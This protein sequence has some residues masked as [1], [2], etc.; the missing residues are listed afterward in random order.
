MNR[1]EITPTFSPVYST[2]IC[3]TYTDIK[4]VW[5]FATLAQK[6]DRIW[7]E[8]SVRFS[9]GTFRRESWEKRSSGLTLHVSC[10]PDHRLWPPMTREAWEG[11]PLWMQIFSLGIVFAVFST[12]PIVRRIGGKLFVSFFRR[13]LDRSRSELWFPKKKFLPSYAGT[14]P[15]LRV[16]PYVR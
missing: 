1:R 5:V 11:N 12:G 6:K 13:G 10:I 16:R 8:S 3:T 4:R 14:G 7:I 9:C 15:W 2:Y